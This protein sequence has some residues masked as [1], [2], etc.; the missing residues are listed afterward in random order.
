MAHPRI[1]LLTR[2]LN[3]MGLGMQDLIKRRESTVQKALDQLDALEQDYFNQ[4]NQLYAVKKKIADGFR[5]TM[6]RQLQSIDAAIAMQMPSNSNGNLNTIKQCEAPQPM[7]TW[8]NQQKSDDTSNSQQ[9]ESGNTNHHNNA[10]S[11]EAGFGV[12]G[13]QYRRVNPQ[14]LPP[15]VDEAKENSGYTSD[16]DKDTKDKKDIKPN[17]NAVPCSLCDVTCDSY[18]VLQLHLQH[19]HKVHHVCTHPGCTRRFTKA[20]DLQRH[21]RVHDPMSMVFECPTCFLTYSTKQACNRHQRIHDPNYVGEV[22]EFCGKKFT[23]KS[24]LKRH[25]RMHTGEK[26]YM[27]RYCT[28]KFSYHSLR[29]KHER[30]EHNDGVGIPPPVHEQPP[31]KTNHVT[32]EG[33]QL[34]RSKRRRR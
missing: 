16:H 12:S 29:R 4:M 15:Q 10:G 5:E 31:Q 13:V 21:L 30:R 32:T 26:P 33:R 34:R 14:D 20:H 19:A 9:I 24:K 3:V 27:C 11:Q 23:D 2:E 7:D 28:K 6:T 17:M 1:P 8:W 22:C 25:R 18:K